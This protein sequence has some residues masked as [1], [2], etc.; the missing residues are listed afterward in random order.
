MGLLS[1]LGLGTMVKG[2]SASERSQL[3]AKCNHGAVGE[4]LQ[5]S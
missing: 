5:E 3:L 1:R 4:E 2:W